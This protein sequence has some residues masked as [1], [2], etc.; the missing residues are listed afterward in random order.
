MSRSERDKGQRGEREVGQLLEA[1]DFELRALAHT[2]DR[3][4]LAMRRSWAPW[5]GVLPLE[6]LLE[7]LW[8]PLP[9]VSPTGIQLPP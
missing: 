2:G 9:K 4:L 7:H 3:P 6:T 8:P 1:H 5:F